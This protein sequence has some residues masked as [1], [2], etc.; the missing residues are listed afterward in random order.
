MTGHLLGA[1]GGLEA[2]I[3]ALAIKHQLVPPTINYRD[4]RSG[5]RSR[6]RAEHRAADGDPLRAV[7]LVRL[8]RHQRGAAVQEVRGVTRVSFQLPE[9]VQE[10]GRAV[11]TH[12]QL[13]TGNWNWQLEHHENCRL[14]QAGRHPRVAA[15]GQ[16]PEDLDPR[17]RRQLRA[18]RARCLCARGSAAAQGEARRRSRGLLR[19]AGARHAGDPRGAG[20]RRGSRDP[21]RERRARRRP[22][23]RPSPRRWPRRSAT[24]SSIWC[25]PGCSPTTRGSARSAS[26][27][28]RS[29]AC[30]TPRSSWK[31]RSQ[32]GGLRVKRELEGGWF[33]WVALPLPALLT[34]QSGINQ[35][36]YA[37][38]RGS[39]RRRRRRSARW[40]RPPPVEPLAADPVGLRSREGASR[41]S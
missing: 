30:R 34:I 38:S 36:R 2:G 32:D 24:S 3:T 10:A 14:H 13:A 7:E 8:R 29:S 5:V 16:R 9:P 31:C 26:C 35:L 12:W 1:A 39:W 17:L 37:R 18:E 22:M 28:P 15:A 23:P 6:L 33:Q 19:R 21:C 41:R 25:S 20:A 4:A 11:P 40:P 27:S